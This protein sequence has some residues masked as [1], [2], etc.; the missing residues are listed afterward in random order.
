[1]ALGNLDMAN[2]APKR[3]QTA[4]TLLTTPV[5][6]DEKKTERLQFRIGS[7][8]LQLFKEVCEANHTDPSKAIRAFIM[9]TVS[10]G[11][12]KFQ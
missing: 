3:S 6:Q 4:A 11:V 2:F 7:D 9:D 8:V 10:T 12:L 1:M 5:Q